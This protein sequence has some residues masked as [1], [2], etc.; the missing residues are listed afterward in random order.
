MNLFLTGEAVAAGEAGAA[1]GG[2]FGGSIWV[3]VIY[4]VVIVEY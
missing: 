3:T 2:M 1:T 4:I